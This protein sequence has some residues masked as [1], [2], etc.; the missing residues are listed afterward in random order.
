MRVPRDENFALCSDSAVF[1]H[2]NFA[3]KLVRVYHAT[4]ADDASHSKKN[5][6]RNVVGDKFLSLMK[7]RVA[8]VAPAVVPEHMSIFLRLAQKVGDLALPAIPVLEIDYDIGC[9]HS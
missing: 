2:F 9:K 3:E 1:Q 8:S 5:S 4:R 6:R 7:N